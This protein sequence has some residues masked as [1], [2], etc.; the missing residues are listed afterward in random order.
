MKKKAPSMTLGYRIACNV[1]ES[2]NDIRSFLFRDLDIFEKRH[3]KVPGGVLITGIGVC[4]FRG[5]NGGRNH[6][7]LEI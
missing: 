5:F 4:N 1:H 3:F 7:I 2:M 6:E